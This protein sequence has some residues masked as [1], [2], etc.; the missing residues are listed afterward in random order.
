MVQY[1]GSCLLI[2][3][4]NVDSRT[5]VNSVVS[6]IQ[7]TE[8]LGDT[9]CP[10]RVSTYE[11]NSPFQKDCTIICYMA[12]LQ[13]PR[14]Q[15]KVPPSQCAYLSKLSHSYST[16]DDIMLHGAAIL[17]SDD[18]FIRRHHIYYTS[19]KADDADTML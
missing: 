5:S 4:F 10:L 15:Q 19:R 1:P 13:R 2:L 12:K 3:T 9:A 8:R 18:H 7:G 14:Q 6:Q 17:G 11:E 16:L